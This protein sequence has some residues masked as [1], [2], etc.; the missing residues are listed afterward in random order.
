MRKAGSHMP[1]DQKHKSIDSIVELAMSRLDQRSPAIVA[2]DDRKQQ[3][4]LDLGRR[5]YDVALAKRL[6]QLRNAMG[7]NAPV[8]PPAPQPV[9][10]ANPA[11]QSRGFRAG[12]LLATAL[13]SALA[14]AAAM[15]LAMGDALPPAASPVIPPAP[16]A[17]P[18]PAAVV[19]AARVA[20]VAKPT[21]D[22]QVRE[23]I[24][25]WR[26]A[27]AGRNVDAY[28]ATYSA[29]FTP[30][31]GQKHDAW[32]AARR[33]NIS[34]RSNIVVAANDLT[35]ERLDA[36]RMKARFLQDYASGDYRETAQAKTLLLVRGET[37]WK[38]AGE[39]Q[40]EAPEKSVAATRH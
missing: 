28:L 36:Q 9:A 19:E 32:V 17:V 15:R 23:L 29:D 1:D 10:A 40:G 8:V 30:A 11:S 12:T 5:D 18:A 3:E 20:P 16:I 21:D 6:E 33:K 24:E 26:S 22:D 35:L 39:W 37:G 13:L 27:W 4:R 7:S 38:I 31:N 25:N 34:S 2:A 14:G